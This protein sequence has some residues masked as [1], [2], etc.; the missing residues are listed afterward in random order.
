MALFD[1]IEHPNEAPGEIVRRFPEYGSGDFRL[2]SQLVVR[3]SQRAVF[4]R[5]GK[6]LDLFGPGRHTLSTNNIPL[7]TTLIGLPFGGQSPF[8]AEVVFV[9]MRDFN[10]MKWGSPQPLVFRDTELGMVR[11]RAFGTYAMRVTDPQLFV[12]Q[13]VGTRGAFSTAQIDEYLRGLIISEFNDILAEVQTSILDLAKMSR[14]VG[15]ATRNALGDDFQQMGLSLISFQIGAITPP[16]EV[17]RRIDE[18]SGMAALGD[19]NTYTQFQAAQ[20]MRDAAQ[21]E[22][23]GAAA[24]GLGLGAGVGLGQAMAGAFQGAGQQAQ[25]GQQGQQAPATPQAAPATRTCPHCQAQMPANARFCPTCG[26]AV[27]AATTRFCP[28]CGTENPAS[29][30][31]CSNCGHGLTE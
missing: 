29:N 5:D 23:G 31:F 22:S 7:L 26:K 17:Q 14:E 8:T 18:R 11:L 16:E 28:E 25:Q 4:F 30:K 6:A 19:M 27:P 15:D 3:E 24:A 1:L 21:N 2:G 12:T 9:S 13:V 20:A 10:E